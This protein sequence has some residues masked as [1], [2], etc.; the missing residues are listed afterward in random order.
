M[1]EEESLVVN[2]LVDNGERGIVGEVKGGD[3]KGINIS[4]ITLITNI[5]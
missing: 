5:R 3:R 4:V 2:G 1:G